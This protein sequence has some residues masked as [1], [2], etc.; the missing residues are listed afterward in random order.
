MRFLIDFNKKSMLSGP[1]AFGELNQPAR[2]W[3]PPRVIE[4]INRG[5]KRSPASGV[6]TTSQSR[7][8]SRQ[9]RRASKGISVSNVDTVLVMVAA[10]AAAATPWVAAS[11]DSE[12][13]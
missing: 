12:V 11:S 1:W 4:P 2:D 3:T 13:D 10:G 8:A 9:L 7:V 5:L 6:D